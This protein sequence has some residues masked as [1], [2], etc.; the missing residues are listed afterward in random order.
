M[1]A[2]LFGKVSQPQESKPLRLVAILL[3]SAKLWSK[4]CFLAWS[5]T[6]GFRPS[7][8][9]FRKHCYGLELI[10]TIRALVYR[11]ADRGEATTVVQSDRWN[12]ALWRV[13]EKRHAQ[14]LCSSARNR[15]RAPSHAAS[16]STRGVRRRRCCPGGSSRIPSR[17]WRPIGQHVVSA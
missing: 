14:R 2:R 3:A 15:R 7:Q 17:T 4:T 10:A 1:D 5:G 11:C 12:T 13:F 8:M 16:D 9:G 6:T